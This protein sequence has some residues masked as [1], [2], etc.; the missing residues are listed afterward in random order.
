MYSIF[1]DYKTTLKTCCCS[2]S[3]IALQCC[4]FS[5]PPGKGFQTEKR[6]R[7]SRDGCGLHIVEHQ[8]GI[9]FV[10]ASWAVAEEA[11]EK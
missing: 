2:I 5:V 3:R 11:E 10:S 7:E 1:A 9:S 8:R 6:D 4:V